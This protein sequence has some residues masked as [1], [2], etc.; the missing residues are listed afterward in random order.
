MINE[1]VAHNS[2]SEDETPDLHP[3]LSPDGASKDL[4][5]LSSRRPPLPPYAQG[6]VSAIAVKNSQKRQQN[7]TSATA[8]FMHLLR[9]NIGLGILSMPKAIQDAGYVLGP[10]FL[11]LMGVLATHCMI[12]LARCSQELCAQLGVSSLDYADVAELSLAYKLRIKRVSVLARYA[13][14]ALIVSAQLGICC[15]YFLFFAE[16]TG[17]LI[18]LSGGPSFSQDTMILIFLPV[19]VLLSFIRSLKALAPLTTLANLCYLYS[20]LAYVVFC[21]L[22]TFQRGGL[23][24]GTVPVV[25][26]SYTY[27]LYFGN[28]LFAFEGIAVILPVENK[29]A[30]PRLFAPILLVT[31]SLV[32]LFDLIVG[33]SG[34]LAL[35]SQLNPVISLDF[36][37]RITS[38]WEGFYPVAILYLVAGTIGSY[39][40]QFY[41]PMDI[42]ESSLL[43]KIG[44]GRVKL[45]VQL[46]LRTLF[47]V[48]TALVPILIPN[49]NL[50]IDLIGACSCSFLSLII[51]ALLEMVVFS[52]QTRY[53]LP[54]KAWVLKDVL[55]LTFGLVGAVFGTGQAL[56]NIIVTRGD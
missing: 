3:M 48:F 23:A 7:P 18:F 50:L 47:V 29:I 38:P 44:S 15:T 4:S 52:R 21:A 34:Y 49:L 35:G 31:I 2:S 20:C 55:I 37:L 53:G 10:L 5:N 28:V 26:T 16:N 13:V 1:D 51:P 42:F 39:L 24:P 32:T 45:L 43:K 8:T 41:V 40:I 36:P 33:T 12:L 27:A 56:F 54:Y 9:S 25:S 6:L 11:V 30:K 19:I 14:N 17:R 46:M 22:T